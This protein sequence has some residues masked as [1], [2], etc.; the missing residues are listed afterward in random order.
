[1]PSNKIRYH[2]RKPSVAGQ[3][4]PGEPSILRSEVTRL[5]KM[6]KPCT[7]KQTIPLAIIVPH[8]GYIFSGIT[9]AS[10]YNQ[11]GP[12][13]YIERVF[14]L[15]SSHQMHYQG[16]SIY[17]SGDYETPLGIIK[18]DHETIDSLCNA[19][20]L[21]TS[22]E[23]AHLFE[24]SLE[25][26][27]PF[28]QV[29]LN[30]P[31][32]LIPIILGTH[33]AE[34]CSSLAETLSPYLAKRNLFIISSDFSHYPSYNDA[35]ENDR[36][37]T[38][39]ILSNDPNHLINTLEENRRLEIPGLITS[40]CSWTS[41][42]TLLYMTQQRAFSYHW[43]DYQNSGDQTI[44]GDRKRVVGYSSIAIYEK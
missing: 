22:R 37:T 16:A 28:L 7:Q 41:V 4:Y 29:I 19:N 33:S 9:A 20:T 6:A 21:F 32:N 17:R 11:L 40:L 5:L 35:I 12:E 14:I 23:D 8:A 27:L 36:I 34:E 38:N 1:M 10:A 30:K 25:V 24:H 31:F 15:A 13:P 42:L 43:I 18:I 26:Q 39:A 44:Y 2:N 3:F